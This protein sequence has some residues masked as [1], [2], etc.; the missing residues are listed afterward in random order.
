MK[1]KRTTTTTNS[2]GDDLARRVA[3]AADQLGEDLMLYGSAMDGL[4]PKID[5]ARQE[6]ESDD[7][8]A[9][10]HGVEVAAAKQARDI[11]ASDLEDLAQID[12]EMDENDAAEEALL[13]DED[14]EPPQD[15][16]EAAA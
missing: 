15:D 1:T 6:L 2:D 16:V 12:R 9:R 5:T 11:I 7:L 3:Q 10:L 4:Q 14:Q 13:K 8:D